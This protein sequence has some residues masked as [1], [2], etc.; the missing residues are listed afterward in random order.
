MVARPVSTHLYTHLWY[1]AT[2]HLRGW[3][4][5]PTKNGCSHRRRAAHRRRPIGGDRGARG[6]R[7][8]LPS[9]LR[10]CVRGAT[11]RRVHRTH[12]AK[13]R[14]VLDALACLSCTRRPHGALRVH[15]CISC[16]ATE[17]RQIL[18]A[19]PDV[20]PKSQLKVLTSWCLGAMAATMHSRV[21]VPVKIWARRRACVLQDRTCA[22]VTLNPGHV[23]ADLVCSVLWKHRSSVVG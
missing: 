6:S 5:D 9:R 21:F 3:A 8:E 10:H 23:W 12:A 2:P 11:S 17:T 4:P 18:C 16:I 22:P 7:A 20:W 19:A 1:K 14:V 15:G 13:A